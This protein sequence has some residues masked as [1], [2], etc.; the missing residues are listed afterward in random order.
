MSIERKDGKWSQNTMKFLR[1]ID[2]HLWVVLIIGLLV[3]IGKCLI[4]Y[5]VQHV[6]ESDA[7]GYAEMADSLLHGRWLSVDYISFFF[8]KYPGMPRPEDHW[9][10]LY[11]FLIVPFY[12]LFGKTAFAAKLPSLI[13]SSIFLPAATY[14]LAKQFSKNRWAA[15]GAGFTVL[16]YPSL[17]FWSLYALSDITYAFVICLAVLFA[18]KGLED[19]RYFY[20]MGVCL[21]LSYYAKGVTLALIP[22]FP[23]FYLIVKGWTPTNGGRRWAVPTLLRDR[24]FLLGMLL[25]FVIFA[26]WWVRNTIHF[27]KPLHSTQNYMVEAGSPP[28]GSKYAVYWDK[29]KPS[30]QT[31]KLP[32]GFSYLT[33]RTKEF[34]DTHLEWVFVVMYPNPGADPPINLR[35]FLTFQ[36]LQIC[37]RDFPKYPFGIPIGFFG[38]PALIG[39]I[40]LRRNRQIYIVPL[41]SAALVLFLS[42]LWAPID[43]L[44][45][46]TVALVAALGWTS[47]SAFW[48]KLKDWISD[49]RFSRHATRIQASILIF[50]TLVV[51][52]YNLNADVRLWRQSARE[53]KYPYV[54]SGRK[55]N[56]IIAAH[57]LRDNTPLNAIV[58]DPEPWDL[59]FYSDRKTVHLAY[60]TMERILWVMR[61]YGVTHITYNGQDSL[62]PL[63]S[64]E[65]P[66]F[67][68]V[69]EEGMKIYR[70]RYELLPERVRAV[71]GGMGE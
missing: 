47:Y 13:I 42:I 62:K 40:F 39:L 51:S 25:A 7:S 52:A 16:F 58:M 24:Q 64:G 41:I 53:G 54:D 27:G 68:L 8:L 60:D 56:R 44:V 49:E 43:R 4:V 63:Y 19:G 67:E 31:S 38:I 14:L 18:I 66:G 59:H 57:W 3:L 71:N 6:G 30:F 12:I 34:L 69:N 61:T 32:R 20:P 48:G 45:L 22:V 21:G 65:M 17:F 29:P 28:G 10:P 11:S 2:S 50:G 70:V 26:P 35:Y 55:K 33:K 36:P 9:P 15:S 1:R 23:L 5:P 46:P 37:F